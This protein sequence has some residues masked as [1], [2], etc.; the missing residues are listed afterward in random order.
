MN[1]NCNCAG[2]FFHTV[3]ITLISIPFFLFSGCNKKTDLPEGLNIVRPEV[4]AEVIVAERQ[5][6]IPEISSFG[7]ITFKSKADI[8]PA[9]DGTI[10]AIL[11]EEGERVKQGWLLAVIENLQ[12]EIQAN[13]AVTN[14][15]QAEAA[16]NLTEVKYWEG[17]LQVDAR[18]LSIDKLVLT[19][20]QQQRELTQLEQDIENKERLFEIDGISEEQMIKL[21]LSYQ[22]A[23]TAYKNSVKELEIKNI[24]FRDSDIVSRGYTIPENSEERKNILRTINNLTLE[25]EIKVAEASLESALAE[26]ESVDLLLDELL[27]RAPAEGVI[28]AKYLEKGERISGGTKLFTVFTDEEVYVVFPVQEREAVNLREGQETRLVIPALDNKPVTGTVKLVSPTIDPQS[29]NLTIKALIENGDHSLK[30]GMFAKVIVSYGEPEEKIL[31]PASSIV[32]KEGSRGYVLTLVNGRVFQR[33]VMIGAEKNG[34][35]EIE[36]GLKE[37]ELIIDSPSPT[38][39]EGDFVS[40]H[41]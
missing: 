18:L 9:V 21:R 40:N 8:T 5:K 12:L 38:L 31:I 30:P 20:E 26:K 4:S 28:G 23:L 16:L 41:S 2:R 27:V 10:K 39:R 11:F 13:Q 7:S 6:V 1:C 33:T 34:H 32:K 35:I 24:G 19:M 36:N 37:G 15:N 29:G 25:A 22:S 14:I 17:F 3:Y